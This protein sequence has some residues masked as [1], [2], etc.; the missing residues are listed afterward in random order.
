MN[1]N[2]DGY[3]LSDFDLDFRKGLLGEKAVAKLLSIE[4]VEVKSD[5]RWWETGNLYVETECWSNA[6]QKW[7]L[8]G[9]SITKATHWAFHLEDITLIMSR[10][11]LV[12]TVLEYG[13]KVEN[14]QPPNPSRGFLVTVPQITDQVRAAIA[15]RKQEEK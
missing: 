12:K 15:Q 11:T 3:K 1:Q 8:S 4:T 6:E 2:F 10:E 7:K 14:K 5:K 9:L 13:R